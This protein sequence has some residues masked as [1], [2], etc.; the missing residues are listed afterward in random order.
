MGFSTDFPRQTKCGFFKKIAIFLIFFTNFTYFYEKSL[1]N[2]EK[3]GI[4]LSVYPAFGF[5]PKKVKFKNQ[6]GRTP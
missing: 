3:Y 2:T 4:I 1:V 6:K 5:P